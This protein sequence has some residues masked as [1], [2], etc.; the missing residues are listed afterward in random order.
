LINTFGW[1]RDVLVWFCYARCIVL[2]FPVSSTLL[3][4]VCCA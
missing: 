4:H 2:L 3:S 1:L